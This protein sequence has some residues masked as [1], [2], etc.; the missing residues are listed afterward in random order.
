MDAQELRVLLADDDQDDYLITRDLLLG[1]ES[2]RFRLDWV[3]TYQAALEAIE[4]DNHDLYLFDYHLG[5]GDGLD[6]LSKAVARGCKAPIILLTGLD[7]WETDTR[8]IKAGAADYLVKGQLDSKHL[9]RSIRH[10]MERKR[11]KEELGEYSTEVEIRRAQEQLKDAEI[12]AHTDALTGLGNRRKAEAAIHEAIAAAHP[13]SL[14]VF[15]MNGF[16]AINDRYGHNQGDQ[17]LK[18]VA[19]RIRSAVR[20]TDVVCRWGG[21]EFVVIIPDS[22]LAEAQAK[23]MQIQARAF[24]EILL[25]RGNEGIRVS[26]SAGAGV[27]EYQSGETATEFF[28]RADQLLLKE[29]R[30]RYQGNPA[31]VPAVH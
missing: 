21:D 27:A 11:A 17:L 28:E 10:A 2:E 25:N 30:Y 14:L 3:P 22:S 7:D 9:E 24:G 6:L 8:A 20:D 18:V 29:K 12:L 23:A 1:I 5:E 4:G 31:P 15:D 19:Q 26:V 16:K 13:P